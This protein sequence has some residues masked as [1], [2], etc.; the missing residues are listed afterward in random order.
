[1][2]LNYSSL[3]AIRL[4]IL[5][6]NEWPGLKLGLF[7]LYRKTMQS[8]YD[9]SNL[10]RFDGLEYSKLS[11]NYPVVF[12]RYSTSK[13]SSTAARK[14]SLTC[15]NDCKPLVI[16]NNGTVDFKPPFISNYMQVT[17]YVINDQFVQSK[18]TPNLSN[19]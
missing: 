3:I 13:E 10:R 8:T 15:Y 4:V 17:T 6:Y 19:V 5:S 2:V 14:N 7:A 12:V 16:Q 11:S 1:M 9:I 18:F